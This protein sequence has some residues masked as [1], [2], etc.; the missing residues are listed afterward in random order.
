MFL[1][2][3]RTL[4]FSFLF[5]VLPTQWATAQLVNPKPVLK[6]FSIDE[7]LPSNEIYHIIQDTLGY[8][9]IATANGVSRFNGYEFENFGLEDG[10]IETTIHEIYQDYKGRL[11]FITSSG[12]LSIFEDETIKPYQFNHRLDS[13]ITRSRGTVKNSFYVD[14]LDN[15]H[16][17]YKYTGRV[18]ISPEGIVKALDGIYDECNLVIEKL[19]GGQIQV[20]NKNLLKFEILYFDDKKSFRYPI[21]DLI[22]APFSGFHFFY[23]EKS[24]DDHLIAIRGNLIWVRM[25]EIIK[26]LEF[27]FEIIWLSFDMEGNLWVAPIEGGV[28]LIRKDSFIKENNPFLL[29]EEIVTSVFQ[30]KE[31]SYWFTT[32]SSGIFYI[33]NI[34][35]LTYDNTS[36]LPHNRISTV[37]ANKTALYLGYEVGTISEIKGKRLTN[38]RIEE[39]NWDTSPIRFIGIDSTLN[40]IWVCSGSNI[41]K[42]RD[43]KLSSFIPKIR[44]RASYPRQIIKDNADGYW[45]ASSWG[46]RKFDGEQFTYNSREENHFAGLVYS[47]YQDSTGSLWLGTVN[48]VWK[49]DNK[50]Y[51]YLGDD[52]IIFSHPTNHIV[53]GPN[54]TILFAT[55]GVGLVIKDGNTLKKLSQSDGLPSN[56]INKIFVI[57]NEIWLTT[58]NGISLITGCLRKGCTIHK[59]GVSNG[60]PTNEVTS[61]FAR[62][63]MV[64]V[65]TTKGLADRK[66]V[67]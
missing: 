54:S 2:F 60:L 53:E 19:P 14:S 38:Y 37:F 32:L 50:I 62:G 15:V 64:Y 36:G 6:Q 61:I 3:G 63:N 26:R 23:R 43:G 29:N 42:I 67:V 5:I 9:W 52:D 66:S 30:D 48:G 33:P 28:Y 55:K 4:L 24:P 39:G 27:G 1:K 47:I 35:I 13:Y 41:H 16:I 49:Y 7:G 10:L 31:G 25:G 59:I 21:T 56:F 8:I 20:S 65:S 40:H 46:I 44:S 51:T 34:N 57:D 58:P 22:D 12:K 17:S 11:W 45:V 18:I